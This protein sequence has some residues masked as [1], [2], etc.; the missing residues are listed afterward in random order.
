[1]ALSTFQ[2]EFDFAVPQFRLVWH[3][4]LL[5]LAAGIGLVVGARL[6][7]GRGGAL[8]AVA[9]FLL[10]R[11]G[12]VALGRPAHGPHRAALPALRR[13][14]ARGR[15]RGAARQTRERPLRF[16]AL[17]GLGIGTLGLAAEW[18]WSHIWWT[19]PWT[20]AL[21]P[22]GIIAGVLGRARRRA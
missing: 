19:I 16:G 3:P 2:A 12:P 5:M 7:I 14:G 8:M 6:M 11:G 18:A 10:I 13:R 9:V 15:G 21:L 4:I 22:E 17:A 20:A 1:M